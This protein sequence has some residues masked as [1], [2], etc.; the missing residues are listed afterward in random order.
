MNKAQKNLGAEGG[1]TLVE[2]AI[3]MISGSKSWQGHFIL[4]VE[5]PSV[6]H[7]SIQ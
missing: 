4:P 5:V 2:L 1:F 3:V 6:G 7:H